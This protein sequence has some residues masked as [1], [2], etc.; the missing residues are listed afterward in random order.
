MMIYIRKRNINEGLITNN[1]WCFDLLDN[2]QVN[3]KTDSYK[4]MIEALNAEFTS[5]EGNTEYKN[6]LKELENLRKKNNL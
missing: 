2:P 3:V 1:M 5:L 6:I 4:N